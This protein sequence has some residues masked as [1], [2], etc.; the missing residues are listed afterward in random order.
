MELGGSSTRTRLQY[1]MPQLRGSDRDAAAAA[2][3]SLM[4]LVTRL[5]LPR[6]RQSA[7]VPW[8]MAWGCDMALPACETQR[9]PEGSGRWKHQGSTSNPGVEK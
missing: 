1:A 2:D 5:P 4:C 7:R 8:R 9:Q 6:R 3:L